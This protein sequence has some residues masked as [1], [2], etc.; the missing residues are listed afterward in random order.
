M[1]KAVNFVIFTKAFS[2]YFGFKRLCWTQVH[3]LYSLVFQI[4]I[5]YKRNY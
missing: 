4:K 5:I 3:I 1:I 2:R